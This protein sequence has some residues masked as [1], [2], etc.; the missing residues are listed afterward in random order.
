MQI[1]GV[2]GMGSWPGRPHVSRFLVDRSPTT[3]DPETH[4]ASEL[5]SLGAHFFLKVRG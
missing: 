5:E 3:C 2:R 1:L 4:H